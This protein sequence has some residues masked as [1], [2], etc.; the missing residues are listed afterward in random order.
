MNISVPSMMAVLGVSYVVV[1]KKTKS[2]GV[3]QDC[4]SFY[5][6]EL[7]IVRIIRMALAFSTYW[8]KILH[9]KYWAKYLHLA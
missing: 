3:K 9:C 4:R 7:K 6:L 5:I 1:E 2:N 8:T